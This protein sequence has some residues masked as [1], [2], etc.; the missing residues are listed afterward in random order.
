VSQWREVASRGAFDFQVVTRMRA[1]QD[2]VELPPDRDY[3]GVI[4]VD[5]QDPTIVPFKKLVN[6]GVFVREMAPRALF[7]LTGEGED[8]VPLQRALTELRVEG[9]PS[10]VQLN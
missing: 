7:L 3:F 10:T 9:R 8:P 2:G 5:G 4:C 1:S 6:V